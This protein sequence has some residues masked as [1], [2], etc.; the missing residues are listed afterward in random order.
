M[1]GG[2]L[3]TGILRYGP[4]RVAGCGI[5]KVNLGPSTAVSRLS[6]HTASILPFTVYRQP[7]YTRSV[8]ILNCHFI[9]L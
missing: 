7:Y 3:I 8:I 1:G 6:G 4:N 9:W 2:G 5:P